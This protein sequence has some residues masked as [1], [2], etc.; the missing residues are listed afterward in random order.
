MNL[1]QLARQF[2][3]LWHVTFSGGG[4]GIREHGLHRA[5][6]LAP[7]QSGLF[8]AEIADA[9]GPAGVR[10]R[11]RNQIRS[12]N[13]PTGSLHGMTADEWWNLVNARVYFFRRDT[14]ADR[15]ADAYVRDG[16]DQEV[17]KVRTRPA[18]QAVEDA[19]EVTKVN[20][21]VFPRTKGPSR[22]RAT[23]IPLADLP[24]NEARDIREITVTTRVPLPSSSV[25]SV[26]RRTV[27]SST[28]LFP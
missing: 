14:D 3:C 16:H 22:G 5:A 27:E 15:L 10:I 18:L 13:D 17:I 2:D 25:V 23:F 12:R 8:R 21:G 7:D 6:D 9:I 26:V 28:R 20:A 19:I 24:A 4:A 1:D 11:L